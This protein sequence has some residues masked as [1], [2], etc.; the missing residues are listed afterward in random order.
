M[1]VTPTRNVN[2]QKNKHT[3]TSYYANL[4]QV[5]ESKSTF[6]KKKIKPRQITFK[7]GNLAHNK[8]KNSS[9]IS[10]ASNKNSKEFI[11]KSFMSNDSKKTKRSVRNKNLRPL[12][13][14]GTICIPDNLGI[15]QE[16]YKN[17]FNRKH[18]ITANSG[19][20]NLI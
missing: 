5:N 18:K 19:N 16:E 2:N 12:K 10:T 6:K 8:N 15:I 1:N 3:T 20:Q 11:L 13:Q 14:R 17:R 9:E 4:K 7:K